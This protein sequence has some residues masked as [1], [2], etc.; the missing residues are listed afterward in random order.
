MN[1]IS[2]SLILL[3]FFFQRGYT[4]CV[5]ACDHGLEFCDEPIWKTTQYLY[6]NLIQL[7]VLLY[8]SLVK[9]LQKSTNVFLCCCLIFLACLKGNFC[10][11]SFTLL[12]GRPHFEGDKD[13]QGGGRRL[14]PVT[15]TFETYYPDH[16]RKV[17]A[18]L[19]YTFECVCKTA[20]G[21]SDSFCCWDVACCYFGTFWTNQKNV[22]IE[23]YAE[24]KSWF[25]SNNNLILIKQNFILIK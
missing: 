25:L 6:N 15:N 3:L 10:I 19:I 4:F 18:A 21:W 2:T 9:Y 20:A 11:C 13:S 8:I 22:C 16:K 23:L 7:R 12:R 5:L 24:H 1:I 14:S 17:C